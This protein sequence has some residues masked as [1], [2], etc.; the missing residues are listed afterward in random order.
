MKRTQTSDTANLDLLTKSIGDER[1]KFGEKLKNYTFT[2][3]EGEAECFYIATSRN[4]LVKV[5]DLCL[6]LR[7]PYFVIGSGTKVLISSRLKGLVIKNR[8]TDLKIA[9]MKGKF[10]EGGLGIEE[11]YIEADSG[12]SLNK[13]NEFVKKQNLV[14]VDGYSSLQSTVG[15][16][17][18]LDPLLRSATQSIRVWDEGEV[19]EIKLDK[20]KRSTV[21]ISVIFKFKAK[22]I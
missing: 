3:S 12:V 20:L 9:G 4:E 1:F 7:I 6:E 11:A 21:V 15:G 22:E 17:I 8:S 14:E 10:S 13:L 19:V 18:F 5:L 2:K 16:A